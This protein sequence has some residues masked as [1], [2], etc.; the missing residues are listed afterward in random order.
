MTL[1]RIPEP[2]EGGKTKRRP[3][4]RSAHAAWSPGPDRADPIRIIE[5][6]DANR[7]ADLVP[8]RHERM[9]HSPFAFYRG[10]AAVMAADLVGTPT[11]GVLVQGCGD[12]H[13]SNFGAFATPERNLIFDVNDFDETLHAPWEWDVKRL[14]AST[15]LAAREID[16][17]E[18]R[19]RKAALS[20]V[21]SYRESMQMYSQMSSLELWYSRIEAA[22]L[23]ER[24]QNAAVCR[25]ISKEQQR[26]HH[27]THEHVPA[28]LVADES[29]THTIVDDAPLVFHFMSDPKIE[30]DLR[31]SLAQYEESLRDDVRVLFSRYRQVDLAMK[32]V[33]IGSV[34]TFCA[35][36]LFQASPNDLL[37]LQIKEATKSV[38]E[39]YGQA[40]ESGYENQGERCATGQRLMQA[41]SDVFLGWTA[42]DGKDF[43][44]RQLRDMKAGVDLTRM[45]EPDLV[46][47]AALCGKALARAHARSGDATFIADY[48]GKSET[49]DEAV[50]DFAQAYADQTDR[51]YSAFINAIKSG[52]LKRSTS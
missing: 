1:T 32:V 38:L 52:R 9:S 11:S 44:I 34:G 27:H 50:A 31:A 35:I 29:G 16:L 5:E 18:K 22:E 40:K 20:S 51:D 25:D 43:Y 36:A 7:L 24:M 30:A 17:G 33:G 15:V 49:F 2:I 23:V 42:V 4:P 41:A 26:A 46:T 10:A 12:S 13:L 48:L 8:I 37:M 47:Y 19:C 45:T 28:R 3:V 21:R 14:A 6:Q 39:R